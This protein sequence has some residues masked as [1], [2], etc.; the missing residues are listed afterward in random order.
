MPK[1]G[2]S[3][4]DSDDDGKRPRSF[5]VDVNDQLEAMLA[6][7][8]HSGVL[9]PNGTGTGFG[10]SPFGGGS[11]GGGGM[12]GGS[13]GMNMGGSLNLDGILVPKVG[14][15]LVETTPM[16]FSRLHAQ[17]RPVRSV[18]V[19]KELGG[20]LMTTENR[21]ILTEETGADVEW[22]PD[23]N[24]VQLRGSAEQVKKAQ[25]VLAR[26]ITHCHWG[27]SEAKVRRLL[28]PRIV[29]S[30]RIVLSPM[31]TLRP[32]DKTLS[33]ANRTLKIGKDKTNDSVIPD[34][35]V[36]R[37]HCMI[38]L[39]SDRGAVYVLDCSTNGTFLNGRKLPSKSS[40]K[41]L[42]SHGDDLLLKDPGAGDQ[43]FG[44][45]VNIQELH[46]KEEVK[47]VAPRRILTTDEIN[48]ANREFL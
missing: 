31:N 43:E 41:V 16:D 12:G 40:G 1:R 4:S 21:Q 23:T 17:D 25:K 37:V 39:D 14:G 19:P 18:S 11:M 46:V 24:E 33:I 26:V 34:A 48:G 22:S 3:G 45:I 7:N 38:E 32:V 6:A 30:V 2:F 29:E 28:K 42:L 27:R 36:S 47:L 5:E 10:A 20:F 15:N 13:K 8:A 9:G 44:F 35:T